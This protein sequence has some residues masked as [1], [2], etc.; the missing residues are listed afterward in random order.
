MNRPVLWFVLVGAV[1]S[2]VAGCKSNRD[3]ADDLGAKGNFAIAAHDYRAAAG[4][5]D[6]ALKLAELEYAYLGRAQALAQIDS[7]GGGEESAAASLEKCSTEACSDERHRL[8]K[9][10]LEKLASPPFSDQAS[11]QRFVRL[12]GLAGEGR[13]CALID[14]IGRAGDADDGRRTLLAAALKAEIDELS[15]RVGPKEDDAT[16]MAHQMGASAADAKDCDDVRPIEMHMLGSLQALAEQGGTAV[17]NDRAES[18]F[19]LGLVSAKRAALGR[20]P[21]AVAA[22]AA[23]PLRSPVELTAYLDGLAKAGYD[24]PCAAF[25]AI[26]RAERLPSGQRAALHGALR[27]LIASLAPPGDAAADDDKTV[28][29]VA[30]SGVNISSGAQSC[31]ELDGFYAQMSAAMAKASLSLDRESFMYGALKTRFE[32]PMSREDIRQQAALRRR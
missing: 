16:T 6:E 24:R 32:R 26:V 20:S 15:R 2:G 27:S 1:A 25:M 8:A 31:E 22:L 29:R 30:E 14:A 21:K 7:G 19:D 3:R 17:D 28:H 5:F 18:A 13:T 9:S 23:A 4:F 12:E 11:L 10:A